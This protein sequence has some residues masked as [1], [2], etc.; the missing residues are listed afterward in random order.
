LA[1]HNKETRVRIVIVDDQL[2][3]RELFKAILAQEPEFEVVGEFA[4]GE[5][6]LEKAVELQ[7]DIT[8][9]DIHMPGM[10]GLTA[11]RILK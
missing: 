7:P 3:A 2:I 1:A 5:A 10:D 8:V 11:T 9:M 6:V 4:S